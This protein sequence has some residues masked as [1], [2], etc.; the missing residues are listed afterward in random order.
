[1]T[2]SRLVW[3][4]ADGALVRRPDELAVEEP[5]ELR[6]STESE[7]RILSITMR[8]PGHDFELAA[9]WLLAEGVIDGPEAIRSIR[10]CTDPDVDGAQRYNIITVDLHTEGARVV[11]RLMPT[12]ASCGICG[13]A[14]IDALRLLGHPP[15]ESEA[16]LRWPT[17]LGLP[18]TLSS[19]QKDF[20]STGGLHA[21]GLFSFEGELLAAREDIGRHNAVDKV[22]GWALLERRFPLTG[23]VLLVS[24]R[25]SFEIVQKAL[26]AGI[27]V[28]AAVSA[29]S[30][31]AA[32]LAEE[33][34]I[35]LVGF[36]RDARCTIY[37]HPERIEVAG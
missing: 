6:L 33:E 25:T 23:A 36:L 14:S 27:G 16:S 13:S 11:E 37:S 24:G 28:V 8:T 15:I 20:R 2:A 18:A 35:T 29:A 5:L 26:R 34:G 21:A 19:V 32:T 1:M 31:L 30:N 9:G 4:Q 10:Y 3:E 17:L 22:I 12:S 7:P